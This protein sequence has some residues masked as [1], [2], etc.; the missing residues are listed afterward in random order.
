MVETASDELAG[1]VMV[2]NFQAILFGGVGTYDTVEYRTTAIESSR[3]LCN[4]MDLALRHQ[5][6]GNNS[7]RFALAETHSAVECVNAVSVNPI[8]GTEF[9]F[10]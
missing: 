9:H 2:I 6:F 4:T 1:R 7:R 10:W 3:S 8:F 5:H